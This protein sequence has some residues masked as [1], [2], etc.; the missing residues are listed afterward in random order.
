MTDERVLA[1][2]LISYDTSRRDE[3]AA[4]AGFVKG[5]LESRE[6]EVREH[7]HN[8]M[9]VLVADCGS[10]GEAPCVVFHGHLDVVPGR[11][12]QFTARVEGDRLIGRGAYDM[13]GGLAAMMCA[14]KDLTSQD[15][16]RVRFVCVPDEESE[17]LDERSTDDFVKRGLGGNFAIT[18]EPT[19]LHIGVEAKGVLVMRIEVHGRAAHSSTPWLGDNAVLKA[20]DVF[21]AIE[22]LPFSRESSEMFDR[23]SI[24]LGRIEGGEALNQVPERCCMAVDV[25]YLPGQDPA[26]ILSQVRAIADID[27][28]R[29]FIHPPVTVARSN[30]YVRALCD[31]AARSL[32]DREVMSVGRDGASDAASFIEAGIPAVE[33]GPV[34]GGHHGPDEWVSLGS[35]ARYRRALGDFVRSLPIWLE[36]SS[37]QRAAIARD[38][39]AADARPAPGGLRAIEGGR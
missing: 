3:L 11:A 30:P 33:F 2:R 9:P 24:N 4:A 6:I 29:T 5:W 1:E 25:R 17:E 23:P 19:D 7:D 34:G 39:A 15:R 13:K 37:S 36:A 22:S 38:D 16:I 20:I 14:L 35:L 28:T 21:R 31:A 32:P 27:V 8:G 26:E 12:E 10:D 18:G